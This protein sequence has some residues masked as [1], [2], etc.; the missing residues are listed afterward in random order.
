MSMVDVTERRG[1][2]HFPSLVAT[3]PA[4]TNEAFPQK[5]QCCLCMSTTGL[6]EN[7]MEG[8]SRDQQ[9]KTEGVIVKKVAAAIPRE[10]HPSPSPVPPLLKVTL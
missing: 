5:R 9:W 8:F 1:W 10:H 3:L 7:D 4:A 6:L 2:R